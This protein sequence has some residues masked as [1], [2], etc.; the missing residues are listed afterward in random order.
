MRTTTPI[1]ELPTLLTPKEVAALTGMNAENIRR[2]CASSTLPA[3]KVGK[4]WLISRDRL[5]KGAE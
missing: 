1:N 4:Q 5:F 3:Y 2:M